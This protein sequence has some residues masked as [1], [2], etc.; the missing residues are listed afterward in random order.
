MPNP[1]GEKQP[2]KEADTWDGVEDDASKAKG[3]VEAE[4]AGGE[5][6]PMVCSYSGGS[7]RQRCIGHEVMVGKC[8]G[9]F[10]CC[11]HM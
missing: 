1:V 2:H 11:V 7:C 8:Y 4:G 5:N 3:N 9:T 6:N 10:I